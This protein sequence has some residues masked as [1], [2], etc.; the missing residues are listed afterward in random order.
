MGEERE[1]ARG[2][3]GKKEREEDR[4]G[5]R[6]G[7]RE[8]GRERKT[9]EMLRKRKGGGE[10][11]RGRERKRERK[12]EI[13]GG[14]EGDKEEGREKEGGGGVGSRTTQLYSRPFP[15]QFPAQAALACQP[16][17]LHR[18]THHF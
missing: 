3:E 17:P 5:E 15:A 9:D 8:R 6:E 12:G 10:K 18:K 11:G 16:A 14:R 1:S 2:R 13:G 4:E 7:E